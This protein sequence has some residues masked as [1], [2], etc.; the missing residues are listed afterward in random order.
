MDYKKTIEGLVPVTTEDKDTDKHQEDLRLHPRFWTTEM[1][2]AWHK[3]IPDLL[4]AFEALRNC[5]Q[6]KQR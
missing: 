3:N 5:K 1:S 4:K 2:E 6:P